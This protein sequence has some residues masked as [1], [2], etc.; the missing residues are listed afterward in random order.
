M[1]RNGERSEKLGPYRWLRLRLFHIRSKF[2]LWWAL[3]SGKM[4]WLLRRKFNRWA[5]WGAGQEMEQCHLRMAMKTLEIMSPSPGDQILELGC[6]EAWASR[7]M[8]GMGGSTSRVVAMDI[9]DEMVRRAREKSAG[10]QNLLFLCGSAEHIPCQASSFNKV[11]SIEAFYY[12]RN[13]HKALKELLRVM[14]PQGELYLLIA[15]HKDN[16]DS[17][18]GV[19]ELGI[20]VHYLSAADYEAMLTRNGW[21]DVETEIF[22]FGSKHDGKSDV[23]DR[24]LL[25]TA[26]KPGPEK[27]NDLGAHVEMEMKHSD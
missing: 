23:H 15:F 13:Q 2:E 22:E 4:D 10:L 27:S 8:V 21:V 7:L 19:D 12:V 11:L 6:G 26:R 16:P 9:S 20:P 17:L 18:V 14:T 24:P 25:I 5:T 3:T 1:S